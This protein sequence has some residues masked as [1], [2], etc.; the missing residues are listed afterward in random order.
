MLKMQQDVD[1]KVDLQDQIVVED[2]LAIDMGTQQI[3]E[4]AF[5]LIKTPLSAL[6]LTHVKPLSSSCSLSVKAKST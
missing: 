2:L 3:E 5:Q 4:R 1:R 6:S